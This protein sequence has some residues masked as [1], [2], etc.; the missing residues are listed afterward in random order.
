MNILVPYN[1]SKS[2]EMALCYA[3]YNQKELGG[4]ITLLHVMPLPLI[5][6]GEIPSFIDTFNKD[7][8]KQE[9]EENINELLVQ[10][11]V[12]PKDVNILIQNGSVVECI[13]ENEEKNS[14]DLIIMGTHDKEGLVD[15]VLGSVSNDISKYSQTPILMVHISSPMPH[16][17]NKILFAIDAVTDVRSTLDL[18]IKFNEYHQAYTKFIHFKNQKDNFD[19]QIDVLL[20]KFYLDNNIKFTFEVEN[21]ETNNSLERLDKLINEEDF[22]L[23]VVVRN[24]STAFNKYFS[25]SFST[26]AIHQTQIPTLVFK[27]KDK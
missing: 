16:K 10:Y 26:D 5:S 13:L 15:R 18:F 22:D 6:P 27:S 2:S 25:R 1:Y 12:D 19:P 8:V 11:K 21:L 4:K 9:I 23:L 24:Q 7:K 14:Y 3:L 17:F 20:H